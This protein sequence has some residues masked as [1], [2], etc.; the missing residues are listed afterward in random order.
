MTVY[1]RSAQRY[2][3]VDR[4][5]VAG[6]CPACGREQLRRYAVIGELGWERVVKCVACLH[7]V[8]RTPWR[9]LGP[10]ELLIDRVDA[11]APR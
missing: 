6:S 1:P 7:S 10:I 11:G 3:S 4:E 9:R 2:L 5:V 8:Q